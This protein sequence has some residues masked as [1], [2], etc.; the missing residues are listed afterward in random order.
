MSILGERNELQFKEESD[1]E[2]VLR[3]LFIKKNENKN[4]ASSMLKKLFEGSFRPSQDVPSPVNPC[5]QVQ[6]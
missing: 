2:N 3:N 6:L 1:I 4:S 5:L